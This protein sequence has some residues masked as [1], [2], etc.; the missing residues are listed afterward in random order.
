[1]KAFFVRSQKCTVGMINNYFWIKSFCLK[2]FHS[3]SLD[4]LYPYLMHT[5][6]LDILARA[7]YADIGRLFMEGN[8]HKL[9]YHF[10]YN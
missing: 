10:H 2:L 3:H 9:R 5:P 1:M 8:L 6:V 7:S 4:V